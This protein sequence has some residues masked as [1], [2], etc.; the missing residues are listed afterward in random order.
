MYPN[1]SRNKIFFISFFLIWPFG[2][3]IYAAI[4]FRNKFSKN[5]VWLFAVFYGFTIVIPH[6]G[7]DAYR[8]IQQ[9]ESVVSNRI[10]VSYVF[11]N[12]FKTS[13]N[14]DIY[15]PLLMLIASYISNDY[16]I[17]YALAGLVFGFF[18]SRN[19]WLVLDRIKS[20]VDFSLLL[21]I[22]TL[23]F[24]SPIFATQFIRFS[25]ATQVFL[26]G[27]LL[28]ILENKKYGV[29]IASVSVLIHFAFIF[30]VCLLLVFYFAP[31][32]LDFFFLY[33]VLA[34]FLL[35]L[36][37][38]TVKTFLTNNLPGVFQPKVDTYMN[39]NYM[40]SVK[41]SEISL[42]WYIKYRGLL[43]TY[44]SYSFIL[45]IYLKGREFFKKNKEYFNLFC[46]VLLIYG[47]ANIIS[48][49]PSGFRFITPS[50]FLLYVL[51][52]KYIVRNDQSSVKMSLKLISKPIL[53][54]YIIVGIR[55]GLDTMGLMVFFG[56]PV[57][58]L[59]I[60]DTVPVINYVKELL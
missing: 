36:N 26:F 17:F 23:S 40:Y 41:A 19:L 28:F 7:L 47:S 14:L 59:F 21:F 42:N 31:R 2:S 32:K 45:L 24:I 15:E 38:Q 39:I 22:L 57:L 44:L 5:I 20:R 49:I 25:T 43:F 18:Y 12:Y 50:L 35:E 58:A 51:I 27:V 30:P 3:L 16:R 34:T 60:N 33:F 56:N 1:N 37:F 4:N 11:E 9:F 46:F 52:I 6:E 53:L 55:I 10:N 54:L 13:D 48:I 29:I 8:Y